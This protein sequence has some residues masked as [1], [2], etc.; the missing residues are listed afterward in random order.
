MSG[1]ELLR[2][3]GAFFGPIGA[4]GDQLYNDESTL[5]LAD[6]RTCR[7][8]H[9]DDIGV[10]GDFSAYVHNV[11]QCA[12]NKDGNLLLTARSDGTILWEASI[13][14]RIIQFKN[15]AQVQCLTTMET[16]GSMKKRGFRFGRCHTQTT[17]RSD[18]GHH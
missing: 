3:D 12:F 15:G 5:E 18:M 9:H 4:D 13:G 1:V 16:S 10:A 11:G 7:I 2:S 8:L 6:L 14:R 17:E